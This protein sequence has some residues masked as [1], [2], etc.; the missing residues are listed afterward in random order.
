MIED[1][2]FDK[3]HLSD[4]AFESPE[5]LCADVE[6]GPFSFERVVVW[7]FEEGDVTDMF[8]IIDVEISHGRRIAPES[9]REELGSLECWG[10]V[11]CHGD[12]IAS[13]FGGATFGEI[14]SEH[15]VV[16]SAVAHPEP[17]L[18]STDAALGLIG[19]ESRLSSWFL[20]YVSEPSGFLRDQKCGLVMP[21]G[22]GIMR[23]VDAV[24][25]PESACDLSGGHCFTEGVVEGERDRCGS[26]AHAVPMEDGIDC[27]G[28]EFDFIGL[29]DEFEVGRT[30]EGEVD[31]M[32]TSF[33]VLS[34]VA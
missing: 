17:P 10:E 18:L 7:G 33:A 15:K 22:D 6:V 13:T 8:R 24:D 5:G 23:D 29:K 27:I 2:S 25:I 3:G 32:C 1:L 4:V 12:K 28:D 9:I 19:I 11:V 21:S 34:L 30:I 20:R 26:E 31:L 16:F 14:S